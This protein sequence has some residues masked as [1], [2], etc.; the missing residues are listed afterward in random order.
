MSRLIDA[1]RERDV[2]DSETDEERRI[3]CEDALASLER[4]AELGLDTPM[5]YYE[6][7]GVR[8]QMGDPDAM[9]TMLDRAI[10]AGRMRS[11]SSPC[12]TGADAAGVTLR[13]SKPIAC[14]CSS[15]GSTS[16]SRNRALALT[17]GR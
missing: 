6:L 1:R 12:A 9:M 11:R 3:R 14:G 7:V 8:E 2:D 16:P 4:S 10:A 17:S 5:L 15:S 13:G